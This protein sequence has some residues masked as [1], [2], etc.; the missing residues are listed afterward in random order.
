M[1]RGKAVFYRV[2][3]LILLLIFFAV[4]FPVLD[5]FLHS[6]KTWYDEYEL[7][8]DTSIMWSLYEKLGTLDSITGFIGSVTY[9][10]IWMHVCYHLY[11]FMPCIDG[12]E[13]WYVPVMLLALFVIFFVDLELSHGKNSVRLFLLSA[14]ATVVFMLAFVLSAVSRN[15]FFMFELVLLVPLVLSIIKYIKKGEG[16]LFYVIYSS[17]LSA[18][19]FVLLTIC[20]C[21]GHQFYFGALFFV[22]PMF[23]IAKSDL[24]THESGKLR[25]FYTS[26]AVVFITVCLYG[27]CVYAPQYRNLIFDIVASI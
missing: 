1:K 16:S 26:T 22:I 11:N 27:I 14:V 18:V 19:G 15:V 7:N 12:A 2:I 21:D 8:P 23:L 20:V 9:G 25:I 6:Q 5:W 10:S 3:F 13:H 24:K 4:N 17:V